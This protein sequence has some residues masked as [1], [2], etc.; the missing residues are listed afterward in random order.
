[1]IRRAAP[2]AP[3]HTPDSDAETLRLTASL[4]NDMVDVLQLPS[5]K[6][7]GALDQ[8]AK[9]YGRALGLGLKE[10]HEALAPPA[11]KPAEHKNA[12]N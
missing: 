6:I 5:P 10:L 8:L 4:A 1:M 11:G 9:R 3:I 7:V 12:K 2:D